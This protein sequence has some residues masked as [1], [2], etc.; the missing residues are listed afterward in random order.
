MI[1]GTTYEEAR[2]IAL[3]NQRFASGENVFG[4][5]APGAST[6]TAGLN[7]TRVVLGGTGTLNSTM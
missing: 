4:L 6:A 5:N 2:A 3:L 7:N 1:G